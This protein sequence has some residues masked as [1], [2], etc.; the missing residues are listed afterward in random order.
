MPQAECV[1]GSL[2]LR[3]TLHFRPWFQFPR[4]SLS[5]L[6]AHHV[7]L[8]NFLPKL[9]HLHIWATGCN[10]H[11]KSP[12]CLQTTE[13][14]AGSPCLLM[15][16]VPR[17]CS[18]QTAN[19]HSAKAGNAFARTIPISTTCSPEAVGHYT[20]TCRH[21]RHPTYPYLVPSACEHTPRSRVE[22]QRA[23]GP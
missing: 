20:C 3:P 16:R 8:Q 15:P 18:T 9:Y 11:K 22:F 4:S 21:T 6:F 5:L 10:R 12:P 7:T 1:S 14:I 23:V 13:S 17:R 19:T 2:C